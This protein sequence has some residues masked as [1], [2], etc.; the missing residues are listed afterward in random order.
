MW[1]LAYHCLS[2]AWWTSHWGPES[3]CSKEGIY[4]ES[5]L[6]CLPH[7]PPPGTDFEKLIKGRWSGVKIHL[8]HACRIQKLSVSPYKN[9]GGKNRFGTWAHQCWNFRYSLEQNLC[10]FHNLLSH[11]LV[12]YKMDMMT[13]T[14][15]YLKVLSE[16]CCHMIVLLSVL[17]YVLHLGCFGCL[18]IPVELCAPTTETLFINSSCAQK[19]QPIL[20]RRFI[21]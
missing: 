12:I 18:Q 21:A 9:L 8:D 1:W 4:M 17:Q 15:Q 6:C 10:Q 11:S 19:I 13:S 14:S 2:T 7:F 3:F 16:A 20:K 5:L